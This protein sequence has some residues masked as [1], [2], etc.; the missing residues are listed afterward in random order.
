MTRCDIDSAHQGGQIFV[1]EIERPEYTTTARVERDVSIIEQQ[2]HHQ[3]NA[4]TAH[5]GMVHCQTAVTGYY[6]VPLFVR[7]DPFKFQPLGRAAPPRLAYRT[8][9]IMAHI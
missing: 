5:Y 1:Q 7:N 6:E 9:G 2:K 8:Q 3:Q 4:G